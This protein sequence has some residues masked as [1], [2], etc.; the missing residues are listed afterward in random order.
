MLFQ[1]VLL[2]NGKGTGAATA[3]TSKPAKIG[4]A[5]GDPVRGQPTKA[6]SQA[7]KRQS[8]SMPDGSN[9]GPSKKQKPD[10]EVCPVGCKLLLL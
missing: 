6:T 1:L 2:Q 5:D 3:Q 7:G 4:G 8:S 10:R 9:V